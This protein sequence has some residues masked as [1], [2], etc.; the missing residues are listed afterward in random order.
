MNRKIATSAAATAS[1]V[2]IG[3][4]GFGAPALAYP[5][6]TGLAVST[7]VT[8]VPLNPSS[9]TVTVSNAQPGSTVTV[10]INRV[11]R[12]NTLLRGTATAAPDG[13]ATFTFK[14]FGGQSG[15]LQVRAQAQA[16][17]Y[18]EQAST[19]V[20]IE[21]RTITAPSSVSV[22]QNF[23]VTVTGYRKNKRI[24]VTAMRGSQ[25]VQVTGRTSATGTFTAN[26]QLPTAGSW[27]VVA[28]SE[29]RATVT[30]VVVN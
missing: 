10:R 4:A 18:Q 30:T 1:A 17:G 23:P 6:G 25:K 26:L 9:F 5:P 21:G 16:P 22:N 19:T 20:A 14:I 8:P 29:G 15:S 13:T 2:A 11:S 28:S 7:N 3:L 24:T 12:N 27:A